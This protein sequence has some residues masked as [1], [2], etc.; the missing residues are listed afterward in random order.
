GRLGEGDSGPA[1]SGDGCGLCSDVA[2]LYTKILQDMP[3]GG[4]DLCGETCAEVVSQYI[5]DGFKLSPRPDAARTFAQQCA[6]CHGE[7][8]Q[9]MGDY[10]ALTA[11]VCAQCAD[12]ASVT[13]YV[14][15][16]M[17]Q[18]ASDLCVGSCAM[19]M[20]DFVA[21]KINSAPS[22]EAPPCLDLSDCDPPPPPCSVIDPCGAAV[23]PE[24]LPP[25][26][27]PPE[28]LPPEELPLNDA[29]HPY[30][31]PVS[32]APPCLDLEDC[33]VDMGA[34]MEAIEDAMA[35]GMASGGMMPAE[36]EV[37]SDLAEE[38]ATHDAPVTHDEPM[39]D[40]MHDGPVIVC[41]TD[42]CVLPEGA[43]PL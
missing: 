28:A 11:D 16:F 19:L 38:G 24:A 37:D 10:P 34:V 3:K 20:G 32:D 43:E 5:A 6:S 9:G 31:S 21:N 26:A 40:G 27:V 39:H 29:E 22:S 18:G 4:S 23:P 15:E 36:W 2:S 30:T 17:P 13:Q 33:N 1:L 35:G 8:G 12:A 25:E 41:I 42:P 7:A 14:E